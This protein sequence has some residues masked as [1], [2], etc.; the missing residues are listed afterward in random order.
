MGWIK[1]RI[2]RNK[3]YWMC[4]A[5]GVGFKTT[6][7]WKI[8]PK[9][10]LIKCIV[11]NIFNCFLTGNRGDGAPSTIWTIWLLQ[12]CTEITLTN[13]TNRRQ[14]HCVT[15]WGWFEPW[16]G[17]LFD[18]TSSNTQRTHNIFEWINSLDIFSNG[19]PIVESQLKC[20]ACGTV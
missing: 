12:L 7:Y 2:K 18:F 11:K 13:E 10:S 1:D 3:D 6:N 5:N 14:L 19:V 20:E 9:M 8:T 15:K 17:L 16:I 4:N